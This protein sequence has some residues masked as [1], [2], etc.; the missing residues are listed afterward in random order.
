M[1]GTTAS[2]GTSAGTQNEGMPLP[3]ES[4]QQTSTTTS[5]GE[6]SDEKSGKL[7]YQ[8][9]PQRVPRNKNNRNRA[10]AVPVVLSSNGPPVP[11]SY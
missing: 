3:S 8:V 11:A 6:A 5:K 10:V 9:L 1:T 7:N 4:A 2:N